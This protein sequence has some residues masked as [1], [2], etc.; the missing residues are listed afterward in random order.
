MSEQNTQEQKR[1]VI[2]DP[3]YSFSREMEEELLRRAGDSLSVH[4]ITELPYMESFFHTPRTID[5]LIASPSVPLDFLPEHTI[6]HSYVMTSE[7]G[8]LPEFPEGVKPLL[9]VLPSD[10]IFAELDKA[11]LPETD[12]SGQ[13][14]PQEKTVKVIAVC[15]P[16]G[17]SGKS[18]VSYALARKLRMLDQTVLLVGCDEMQSIAVYLPNNTF[19][20][21]NLAKALR[22]PGP[23]THWTILQNVERDEIDFLRPFEKDLDTMGIGM[24]HWANLIR[25]MK[26][27]Q[28][29]DY[30][31]LDVGTPVAP[32][33]A[34]LFGLSDVV[35]LVTEEN[36]TAS[37]KLQRLNNNPEHLPKCECILI[38]NEYRTDGLRLAPETIF[39]VL[40]PYSHWSEAVEDP[41]FYQI[42]LKITG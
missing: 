5:V 23:E 10:E 28:D 41:L 1:L 36:E 39:G 4:I 34:E 17:G 14:K 26:E 12:G 35:V 19:A 37:R 16:V 31:V 27:K 13:D 7:V 6:R 18:L 29:F 20:Q 2:V 33:I 42:A 40:A 22:E 3:E 21:E 25:T 24:E 9:S 30:L 8:N 38:A 11:L 15:S 32:N